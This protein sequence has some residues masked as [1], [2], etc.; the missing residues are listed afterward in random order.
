MNSASKVHYRACDSLLKM[1]K[2]ELARH[3]IVDPL[4]GDN[5]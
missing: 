2:D 5:A 4:P 3:G 1:I